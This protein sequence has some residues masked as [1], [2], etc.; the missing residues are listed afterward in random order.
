MTVDLVYVY[1]TM[2]IR[3]QDLRKI[4]PNFLLIEEHE[5]A[6]SVCKLWKTAA[7]YQQEKK[8]SAF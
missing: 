7:G 3:N 6:F 8:N 2:C 5:E 1:K 4:V